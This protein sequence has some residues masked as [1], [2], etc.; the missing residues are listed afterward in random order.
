MSVTQCFKKHKTE[1]SV[2]GSESVYVL[3][4]HGGG[5]LLNSIHWTELLLHSVTEFL[6]FLE[7][8]TMANI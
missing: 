7:H 5:Y 6:D 4:I 2:A 3:R 1:Y 8:W